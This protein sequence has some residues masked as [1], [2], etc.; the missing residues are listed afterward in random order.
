MRDDLL[1]VGL[2]L[3]VVGLFLLLISLPNE[4]LI[5]FIGSAGLLVL[6]LGIITTVGGGAYLLAAFVQGPVAVPPPKIDTLKAEQTAEPEPSDRTGPGWHCTWC[7][8]P[9]KEGSRFCN[10][11]GRKIS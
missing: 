8:A 1:I 5:R 9:L 2:L 6:V 7:W 4:A 10:N 11:C 3:L